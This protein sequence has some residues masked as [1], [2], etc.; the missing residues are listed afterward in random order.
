MRPSLGTSSLPVQDAGES[1]SE[2]AEPCILHMLGIK[3]VLFRI[4]HPRQ[5]DLM[6]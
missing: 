5:L 1:K 2:E 6:G 3:D 4:T